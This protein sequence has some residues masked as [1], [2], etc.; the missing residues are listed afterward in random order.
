MYSLAPVAL[1]A[2]RRPGHLSKA[3]NAL[4]MNELAKQTS[5]Y[6]FVDGPRTQRDAALVREVEGI[7]RRASGFKSVSVQPSPTNKGLSGSL[8]SGI[9]AMLDT[10]ESV[11]VLEDDILVSPKYLNFMNE[12]LDVYSTD[13]DVASVNG[14]VYPHETDLPDTFFMRGADCWG[15]GTWRRAWKAFEADGVRLLREL[16]ER[17]LIDVFDFEGTA[18]FEEMLIDQIEGRNDSWAVRWYA[19]A[20][21]NDML[22]LYPNK[23]MAIN[24]GEDGSGTHRGSSSAYQQHVSQSPVVIERI[25][26]AESEEGRE[27]FRDFFRTRYRIPSSMF[28]RWVWRRARRLRNPMRLSLSDSAATAALKRADSSRSSM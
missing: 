26:I 10:Y 25:P 3:I 16:R 14:C 20:L 21:V 13:Q 11:I 17:D 5:L 18:P 8:V 6:I 12:C 27:A 22:T 15:W 1:F 24:I 4:E 23:P 9:S 28:G 7:A 19:S 2:W